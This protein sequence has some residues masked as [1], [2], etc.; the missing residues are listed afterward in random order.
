MRV[1][2]TTAGA[3]VGF[4]AALVQAFFHVIPP[5]AYG[6]CSA[7]HMRDLVNWITAH[8]YPIYG[9]TKGAIVIPGSPVSYNIPLLT[10]I[11]ILIG[12]GI[13][14]RL[15]SEFR[16]KTMRVTWQKPWL[17]FFWG[18]G[19]MIFAL[20]MG[21]CPLRTA[22]KTAYLDITALVGLIMIFVGVVI[23][24]RVIK[25]LSQEV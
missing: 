9:L 15:N 8:I 5:P 20:I 22:L 19:V 13:A 11:G 2:A 16:W 14:A 10:I 3:I 12:A 17:E 23:G 7:C 25:K 21:G 1:T 4:L 24:C 6:I 18:M